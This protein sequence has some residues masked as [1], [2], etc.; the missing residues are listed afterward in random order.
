MRG[1]SG[2]AGGGAM[3]VRGRRGTRGRR[4][5][6]PEGW[7]DRREGQGCGRETLQEWKMMDTVENG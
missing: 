4:V 5:N 3:R 1:A 7:R 2:Q 6:E